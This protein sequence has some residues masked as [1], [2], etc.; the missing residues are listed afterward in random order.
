MTLTLSNVKLQELYQRWR[1][2][3]QQWGDVANPKR[4]QLPTAPGPAGRRV[5]RNLSR[6][7]S[8]YLLVFLGLTVASILLYP[9]L[10]LGILVILL[11]FYFIL[12]RSHEHKLSI[13]GYEI[14]TQQQYIGVGVL[15]IPFLW[16]I[17]AGATIIWV[18]S[19]STLLAVIHATL[20]NSDNDDPLRSDHLLVEHV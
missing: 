10:L 2:G 1:G 19:I 4:Y 18:L 6:F 17:G 7:Q 5:L 3:L 8:N 14:N 9:V 15:S 12:H 11:A 16:I 13:Y 20:F